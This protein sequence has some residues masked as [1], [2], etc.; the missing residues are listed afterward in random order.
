AIGQEGF[1][2]PVEARIPERIFLSPLARAVAE[3][4]KV[5]MNADAPYAEL[6]ELPPMSATD[7]ASQSEFAEDNPERRIE[8]APEGVRRTADMLGATLV[9]GERYFTDYAV[10]LG[11]AEA[12]SRIQH[13]REQ[14]DLETVPPQLWRIA[15]RVELGDLADAEAALRAAERALLEAMARGADQ[16]E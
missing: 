1:S 8:R 12:R 2:E 10:F 11:L 4:R 14:S 6:P 3:Q 15:L 5:L 9:G 7:A 13:A 16:D